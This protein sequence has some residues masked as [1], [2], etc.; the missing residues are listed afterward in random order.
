MNT[1]KIKNLFRLYVVG[2]KDG[3]SC[4]KTVEQYDPH[5]N[6]WTL[7]A[8]MIK[9]RGAVGVGVLNGYMYAVGGYDGAGWSNKFECVETVER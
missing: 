4:L 2:G 8:S 5:T 1:L 3:S 9:R 6:K 7:R